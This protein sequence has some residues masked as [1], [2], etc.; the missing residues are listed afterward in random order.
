MI[1]ETQT[2]QR[3]SET[4]TELRVLLG[5]F[6]SFDEYE[7]SFLIFLDDFWLKVDFIPYYRGY[8]HLNLDIVK[9]REVTNT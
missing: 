2:K 8:S 4:K 7:L 1:R 3:H 9:L 5:R 6:F